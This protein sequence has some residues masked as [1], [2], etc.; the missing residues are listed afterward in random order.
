MASLVRKIFTAA[1]LSICGVNWTENSGLKF[2]AENFFI[3]CHIF[4]NSNINWEKKNTFEAEILKPS[5]V[6]YNHLIL[7]DL[8]F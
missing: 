1:K 6:V 5:L 4:M 8:F 7:V 3:F 2:F